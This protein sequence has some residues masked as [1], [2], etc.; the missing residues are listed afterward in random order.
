VKAQPDP[1][2]QRIVAGWSKGASAARAERLGL[3]PESEFADI[4]VQYIADHPGAVTE[5]ARAAAAAYQRMHMR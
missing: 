2:I 5:S 1:T 3:K 4:I